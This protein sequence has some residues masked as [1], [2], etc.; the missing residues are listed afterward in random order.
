MPHA[1]VHHGRH[2]IVRLNCTHQKDEAGVAVV[3]V[4]KG[5][6]EVA[7]GEAVEEEAEVEAEAVEEAVLVWTTEFS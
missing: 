1:R 2:Q 4:N 5:V 7:V 6:A 3:V